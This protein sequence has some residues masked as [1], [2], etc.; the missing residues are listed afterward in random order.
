MKDSW[1]NNTYL[2][3]YHF[4]VYQTGDVSMA[5]EVAQ[6]GDFVEG[7]FCKL[8]LVK[9]ARGK[10]NCHRLTGNLIPSTTVDVM[11]DGTE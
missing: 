2:G 6:K 1:M 5:S 11:V 8:D 10:L 7:S 3:R 4:C 9:D